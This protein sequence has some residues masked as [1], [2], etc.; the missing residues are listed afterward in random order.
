M[1]LDDLIRHHKRQS[2]TPEGDDADEPTWDETEPRT[3]LDK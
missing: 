3:K 2:Y 1:H